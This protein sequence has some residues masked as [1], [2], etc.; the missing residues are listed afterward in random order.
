MKKV[1]TT[2]EFALWIEEQFILVD[3]IEMDHVK[4]AQL[5]ISYARQMKKTLQ[6]GMLVPCD[7]EG[8]PIDDEKAKTFLEHGNPPFDART[9][10]YWEAMESVL[11]KGWYSN[12]STN[13]KPT[14]SAR[15][16][17]DPLIYYNAIDGIII[18]QFIKIETVE[19][20]AKAIEIEPSP[21]FL[22]TIG[23]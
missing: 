6:L 4:A 21:S 9:Q 12:M 8:T 14:L 16:E 23:L 11:F 20:L 15:W 1:L 13:Q 10:R 7:V 19:E 18:P 17:K 5:I 2:T 3:G 22:K